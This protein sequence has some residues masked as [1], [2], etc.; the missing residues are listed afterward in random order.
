MKT[1]RSDNNPYTLNTFRGGGKHLSLLC[2]DKRIVVPKSL[3]QRI[4][5][6]YHVNLMHPGIVCTLMSIQ[7]HFYWKNMQKDVERICKT[8]PTCQRNKRTT[9]K[10]GHVPPKQAEYQP[11]E[12]V[13]VDT[14]GPYKIK[15]Q[16]KPTL[17]LQCL[18]AIDPAT[19]WIEVFD[20]ETK[21]ADQLANT[22]EMEWLCRYP[23]PQV[24]TLD[25]GKEFMKEFSQ[26]IKSDYGIKMRHITKRNPQ[27]NSMVE[28]CH[29]TIGNIIR[30]FTDHFGELDEE[31]PWQGIIA[32]AKF[33]CH[34]TIHTTLN[35]SPTQLVFGRDAILNTRYEADWNVIRERKQK[36]INYN[37]QKEN[38]KRIQHTYQVNDKIL[39]RDKAPGEVDNK[40]GTPEWEGPYTVVRHNKDTG[41]VYA[42]L[43]AI[44]Q[45][46]NIRK[47][48][49]YHTQE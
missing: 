16:G 42:R 31:R 22:F 6:W 2:K 17:T 11:W 32:A 25:N 29:Q 40:Y 3:Q 13:C 19:G 28:R 12:Q 35:A 27:A 23:W 34:A 18:T 9:Q 39:V 30:T 38:A 33:A 48:K 20:I 24:M 7:Q 44:T 36:R 26:T 8:C 41:T 21:R 45:P 4:A 46:F 15:R 5:Q 49:P 37:N 14:I 43:G 1:I 10:W 47:I